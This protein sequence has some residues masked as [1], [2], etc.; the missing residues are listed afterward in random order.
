MEFHD[1][2]FW[3]TSTDMK[4]ASSFSQP[5]AGTGGRI[6]FR[7][8][9]PEGSKALVYAGKQGNIYP[10]REVIFQNGTAYKVKQVS[11]DMHLRIR[12]GEHLYGKGKGPVDEWH[13]TVVVVEPIIHQPTAK[14]IQQ[15][16][17]TKQS[18]P[19]WLKT[20]VTPIRK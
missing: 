20:L 15:I 17:A 19:D 16:Q 11:T 2:G 8:E 6:M 4:V 3:S 14:E 18:N 13:G 10:E 9:A 1:P 12:I 5:A 7:V